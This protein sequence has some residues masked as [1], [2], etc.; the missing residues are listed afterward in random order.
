[1]ACDDHVFIMRDAARGCWL[2]FTNPLE[3]LEIHDVHDVVTA[4]VHIE[5]NASRLG[6]HAAGMIAYEAAPAF[7]S[8]LAVP[9]PGTFPLLWFGLYREPRRI[10]IPLIQHNQI[11]T[12]PEWR[13]TVQDV[14]Y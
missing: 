3:V 10:A 5:H 7:D 2:E 8:S 1:M 13:A 11:T 9:D 14:E 6:L 12:L 4:M